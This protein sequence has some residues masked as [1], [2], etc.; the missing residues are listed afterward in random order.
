MALT[1]VQKGVTRTTA[2][3]DVSIRINKGGSKTP[4]RFVV[5]FEPDP[6]RKLTPKSSYLICAFD[7]DTGRL[8]FKEDTPM[9]GFKVTWTSVGRTKL[10]ISFPLTADYMKEYVGDYQLLYDR[11]EKLYYIDRQLKL[12]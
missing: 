1:W 11:E 10:Q 8:Y 7:E 9:T 2:R 3:S 5:R 6:V 4:K 12:N